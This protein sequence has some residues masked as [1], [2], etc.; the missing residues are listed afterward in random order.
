MMKIAILI[1]PNREMTA[2]LGTRNNGVPAK[3]F[4][5][6][7][8]R[9]VW[10]YN[11]AQ[12]FVY[13]GRNNTG[14]RLLSFNR[15]D[16]ASRYAASTEA[17]DYNGPLFTRPACRRIVGGRHVIE[18]AG[19]S[20]CVISFSSDQLRAV[21][22]PLLDVLAAQANSALSSL[23]PP[24]ADQPPVTQ[25]QPPVA[26]PPL[27]PE[28]LATVPPLGSEPPT[29][30]ETEPEPPGPTDEQPVS[31]LT[32]AEIATAAGLAGGTALLGSLLMLGASG[33]RRDEAIAAIRDLLRGHVP[34]DPYEAWKRKYEALGWKYSEKDGVATFDPMDGARNEAGEVY[35]AERGGFVPAG[36]GS[37]VLTTAKDGDVNARGEIW[38]E[39]DGG[40]V[41]RAY[42]DQERSRA[43]DLEARRAG[44]IAEAERISRVELEAASRETARF[45]ERIAAERAANEAALAAEKAR[46]NQLYA[47]HLHRVM[48]AEMAE[49]TRQEHWADVMAAGEYASKLT[50]AAAKTGMM[51]VA[52]PAGWISA[53]AGSGIISSAEEG[54][55]AWVAGDGGGKLAGAFAAGFLA[56][57]KDGAVGRYVNMPRISN[58]VK[59]LLP[60]ELDTAETL[61]RT[62]D[63]RKALAAGGLS[64]FGGWLGQK[65][66]NIGNTVTR[67]GAQVLL[68]GFMGAAGRATTDGNFKEGFIDGVVGG[69]GSAAGGR[70][71]NAN[72]PMTAAQIQLDQEA[73]ENAAKGKS[74]VEDLKHAITHGTPE[75][76]KAALH[77]VLENRD[78]KLQLKGDNV[79]EGTKSAFAALTEEHR[80]KPLFEGAAAHLNGQTVTDNKGVTTTRFVVREPD[81]AKPGSFVE[82]EVRPTDIKSGSGS[83]GAAPGMDLDMYAGANII[84][85]KTGHP[86]HPRE[87]EEAVKVTCDKLGISKSQQEI[88]VIHPT[89]VEAYTKLPGEAPKDFLAR[90]N[91]GQVSGSEGRSLSEVT[92]VKL[93]EAGVLHNAAGAASER[94]RTVIKDYDRITSGLLE[95]KPGA[96]LPPVFTARNAVTGETPMDILR[97]V[98]N[99]RMPPGTA[100]AK[101]RAATG[102]SLTAGAEKLAQMPEFIAK[103]GATGTAPAGPG[104]VYPTGMSPGE[105][106]TAALRQALRIGSDKAS[107]SGPQLSL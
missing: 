33:V 55:R 34:E 63:P 99:G 59:V 105:I 7:F 102:M 62:G 75:E 61:L 38:S 106:A 89:H 23:P 32:P 11:P 90:A 43:A 52:G 27:T 29:V 39:N 45:A 65:A 48:D 30:S 47:E 15:P 21:V 24:T 87:L 95:A 66:G 69:I 78:A 17:S 71:A 101:F 13:A 25:I 70:I 94:C 6:V 107:R 56:G 28:E 96:R 18:I 1:V 91:A 51:V 72:V 93:A 58:V 54:A 104:L 19:L 42:W 103:I 98:A 82:R 74:L 84:D 5:Q 20:G 76:Q 80:T 14:I 83:A 3:V 49:A 37:R 64:G 41:Q 40:W 88:N 31:E 97:A 77:R 50:L 46:L 2:I 81:P 57:A 68:G 44:E 92:T 22:G 8:D 86:A 35:S 4:H 100:D 26:T 53:M 67:E 73:L 9:L 10:K 85:K 16:E 79:D 60:A 36:E 12:G